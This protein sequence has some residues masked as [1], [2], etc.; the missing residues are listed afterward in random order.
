MLFF[1][2]FFFYTGSLSFFFFF[3]FLMILRPPRST[4]T[5]TLFPYTTLF[6]SRHSASRVERGVPLL[7][8]PVI[9]KGARHAGI[10]GGE[11]A[12]LT[13]IGDV[14]YTAEVQDGNRLLQ[15]FRQSAM[16]DRQE[17]R[18]LPSRRHIGA[19]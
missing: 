3:F 7:L 17:R 14:R 5:D 11:F 18:A 10:K 19:A 8:H 9:D 4:R 1:Y 6:R 15:R 12:V 2:L 13:N 16:I